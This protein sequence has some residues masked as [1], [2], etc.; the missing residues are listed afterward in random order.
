MVETRT[1]KKGDWTWHCMGNHWHDVE[2]V[3]DDDGIER[4]YVDGT[5]VAEYPNPIPSLGYVPME[6]GQTVA[7]YPGLVAPEEQPRG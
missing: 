1:T 5:L 3:Y 2:T 7:G 6:P 4:L